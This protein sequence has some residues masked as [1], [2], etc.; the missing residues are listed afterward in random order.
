MSDITGVLDRLQIAQT[1]ADQVPRSSFESE[2]SSQST[3]IPYQGTLSPILEYE[4]ESSSLPSL[5]HSRS[6]SDSSVSTQDPINEY[7]RE[8]LNP[9]EQFGMTT[10]RNIVPFQC[11]FSFLQCCSRSTNQCFG[12]TDEETWRLHCS[13][14]LPENVSPRKIRCPYCATVLVQT[15]DCRALD[16]MFDHIIQVHY[17]DGASPGPPFKDDNLYRYLRQ[18]NIISPVQCCEL[19]DHGAL[20]QET[21]Q[22]T[23]TWDL[24]YE[25]RRP[26]KNPRSAHGRSHGYRSGGRMNG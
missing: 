9:A 10:A 6:V 4:T 11:I 8:D 23:E 12:S 5:A 18:K 19:I 26:D 2:S 15:A 25:R 16:V 17:A 3:I 20:G 22:W 1:V 7:A 24:M 21:E 14:H 13:S